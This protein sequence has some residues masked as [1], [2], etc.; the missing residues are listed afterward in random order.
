MAP[1]L[2]AFTTPGA[3][4]R[5]CGCAL[6]GGRP[7]TRFSLRGRGYLR[8]GVGEV[9]GAGRSARWPGDVRGVETVVSGSFPSSLESSGGR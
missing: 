9:H 2:R 4:A 7:V 6:A 5:Q 3:R 1:A 8:G